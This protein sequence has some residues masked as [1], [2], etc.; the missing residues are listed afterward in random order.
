MR[1]S[2]KWLKEY[3]D[4]PVSPEELAE[5]I[6][7]AGVAVENIEY[8]G[9]GLDKIVT[10]RIESISPHPDADKLV[11]CRINIGSETLQV[12][13]GAPNVRESQIILLALVGA[14]LPGGK[15]TKAKLRGVE[16]FGM[17]CSAQEMGLD[18]KNF[19]P[20]QQ[21]GILEF[22]ADTPL[23]LDARELLGLDD[24]IL[25]LELTPNRAD[26]LSMVGVAREVSAVLGTKVKMPEIKVGETSEVID[27]QVTVTINNPEL[28]GRYVGRLIRNVKIEPSPVWMQHRLQAAGIRP[29]SNIVDV[30]NYV[31]M[32][33]GQPL[34]AF[35]Y[36]KLRD[37]AIIVRK[38]EP[39]EKIH[40]LD[41]VE[42]ELS[43]EMLVI[44][45]PARPVAIAGVM[46]GLDTEIT[47]ETA[48]VLIESAY[49]NPASIHRTS[50]TLALQS[51]SSMRFAK[52]IDPNGCLLAANRACQLIQEM[53]AGKNVKGAVDNFP[54]PRDNA[55]I[56]LRPERAAL[57]IGTDVPTSQIKDI[58]IK[59]GFG[60]AEDSK[61][62][63]VEVPTRRGDIS[64][65]ID[66]IEEVARLF[67]YNNI[68][69]TLPEGAS[70]EGRKTVAQAVADEVIDV[71]TGGGLT[72]IITLSFMNPKVLD[73]L[74]LPADD[75]LREVVTVE[76]PLSEEQRILRTTMLHGI[77]DIMSRNTA[78]KN[79]DLAFFEVGRVFTPV[80]GE[81]LPKET[82]TL[83][84]G[85]MGRTRSGWQT[86][87][88]EMDFYYLKGVL[89]TLMDTLNITRYNIA[90]E[91]ANPTFHPGRTARIEL[92]GNVV[93]VIG[94]VH[95]NV[96]DNYRLSEKVLALQVNLEELISAV[97][98]TR[99][100]S[101]L[102][103]Y[104]AI[105]RDIAIVVSKDVLSA[106]VN[107][108]IRKNAGQLLES[109]SL[110][111]LYE[112]EQIKEGY[113][114]MAFALRFQA[115]DRTLTD[116][117]VNTI[118]EKIQKA[119]QDSL[120]AELRA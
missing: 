25:E 61:G 108:T 16:S 47:G 113:K 42:R 2:Y 22:A 75:P 82:L 58:M 15:I 34:H 84:A 55:V 13:T 41:D 91:T 19:P 83:A 39:G 12:V 64:A 28:C 116:E 60:V 78:R 27:G 88:A 18:P 104:P 21:E 46:G 69:T 51:E 59:L 10:G 49:F 14:T 107:R 66:L 43:P 115:P 109:I 86:G 17:L 111:D 20:D 119:L 101:Q 23:G 11:V 6:T 103:K 77:F 63:L 68:P 71:M 62:F 7:M 110:F 4:I 97:G 114:S 93:G 29:I 31:L 81:K 9:R 98:G 36:D 40:S 105:E 89:E 44:A 35:D 56:R 72:E 50:K 106:D 79:K 24:A 65:E 100:Y 92:A 57:I 32:E 85:V 45:D 48:S 53:G 3:V 94:E 120:G 54:V 73:T 67:G 37:H 95:P 70:T 87:A 5:K 30:T 80:K 33:L 118:H 26:C 90:P 96:T 76:N 74:N 102:P 112:G 1:V 99:K 38:A 8:P 117:E 52:G